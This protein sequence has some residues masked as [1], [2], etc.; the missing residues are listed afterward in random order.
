MNVVAVV[1]YVAN[2]RR[3]VVTDSIDP[4]L[5][6][7]HITTPLFHPFH[8]LRFLNAFVYHLTSLS[9]DSYSLV[10]HRAMRKSLIPRLLRSSNC[11]DEAQ[12]E[13]F[14]ILHLCV[15]AAHL[16]AS[17]SSILR[18]RCACD[19]AKQKFVCHVRLDSAAGTD[20]GSH[21]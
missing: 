5:E 20:E 1:C 21:M 13:V 14:R 8:D 18:L 12:Q 16:E 10:M 11:S 9:Q 19:R 2:R 17:S 7:R 15:Y 3:I 4:M 6:T